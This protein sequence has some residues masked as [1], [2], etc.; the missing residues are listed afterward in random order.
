MSDLVI[1]GASVW[2]DGQW[3]AEDIGC[4]DGVIAD[5][6]DGGAVILDATG[7]LAAP[8][9][10]DLQCNGALGIDLASEPERLWELAAALP[11]WG[12]TAWL[13][14]IVTTPPD[15]VPRA[16][17]ALASGPP[18]GWVGAEPLG[19]HLEGPFLSVA[20]KGAHPEALLRMPN[21]AAIDGWSRDGGVALVTL[22]PE[23]DGASEVIGELVRRGVVVSIGHSDALAAQAA[24][25]I[26]AGATWVT[27]LFNAMSPLHHREPGVSGVA[28]T[29]ER[30]HVGLIA[31]GVHVH[32][33][34]VALAQRALGDRLTLVTDAVGAL[35]LPSSEP[36]L[37]RAKVTVDENG[38]RLADGT[39]AGSTLSMDQA[40]RNLVSF[41]GCTPQ[42]A[43]VAAAEAPAR[44]L[45][46]L[47]RGHL[48][49]AARADLVLLTSDLEV[50]ATVVGGSVAFASD[51][52]PRR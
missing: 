51:G 50:V 41:T 42:E 4:R 47:S 46:D 14:T 24:A 22:A 43:A 28:L 3:R 6:V 33:S 30:L 31:D 38:V 25:A 19:L 39:L 27:H 23:L 16:L 13:P 8:G 48:R 44:V 15:V 37:G 52:T 45:G 29:D 21:L 12:V 20:R 40:V 10:I 18:A 49:S 5:E 35:G 2:R 34:V 11:R 7:L 1:R 36:R 9:F 17:A 26:D 32:P